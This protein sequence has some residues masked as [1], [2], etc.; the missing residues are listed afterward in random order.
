MDLTKKRE[1]HTYRGYQL[2]RRYNVSL[3]P[4][5]EDYLEMIYRNCVE[6]GYVRT[7][8]LAHQLHVKTPSATRIDQKLAEKGLL[9]YEKYGI[10]QMTERG[11]EIGKYLLRRHKTV[12]AF[13]KNIEAS[14]DIFIETEMVEHYLSADT[15]H[16]LDMLNRFFH[17]KP[18]ILRDFLHFKRDHPGKLPNT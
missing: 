2:M 6:Y 18:D 4:S 7:T 10:I 11:R 9:D 13:L 14:E 16:S 17:E 3:T 5:M 1:F 12:E 8:N 15:I